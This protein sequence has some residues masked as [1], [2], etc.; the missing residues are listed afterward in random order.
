M[1]DYEVMKAQDNVVKYS[2]VDGGFIY[3]GNTRELIFLAD[4]YKGYW[5]GNVKTFRK[6][7]YE[8]MKKLMEQMMANVPEEQRAMYAQVLEGMTEVYASPPQ[9]AIDAI[10]VKVTKTNETLE[11][12]GYDAIKYE[13]AV[14][15]SV[16]E[17][18]WL[19]EDLDISEDLDVRALMEMFNEIAPNDE[20]E[21]FYEYTDAYLDLFEK[22]F[23]MKTSDDEQDITEVIKVEKKNI[24]D[25]EFEAPVGYTQITAEQL[26]Q[27]SMMGGGEDNDDDD[28]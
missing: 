13:I 7:V 19:S 3:N 18:V 21:L 27:Q 10:N 23:T 6:E 14:D 17:Y 24:P 1:I 12:A 28:W 2:S 8:G 4:T 5:K 16:K 11:I 20:D 9:E 15:G 26:L 22:G 25:S